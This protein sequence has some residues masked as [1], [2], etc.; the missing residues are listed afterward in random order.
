MSSISG[1]NSSY[2]VLQLNPIVNQQL[3][4]D[5]A[6][7][8]STVSQASGGFSK[9]RGADLFSKLQ[10]LQTSDPE[11]FKQVTADIAQKLKDAAD[12]VGGDAGKRLSALADK[13]QQ[14][15]DTGDLSK[16]QPPQQAGANSKVL[17]AYQQN[18]QDGQALGA[19]KHAHH[20]HGGGGGEAA[21]TQQPKNDVWSSILDEV[22]QAISG[23]ATATAGAAE[24]AA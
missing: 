3:T 21:G 19:T 14:V 8:S 6:V 13:F 23:S 16:L 17:G 1:I 15:S 22:N 9:S 5:N 2:A 4:A 12:Q 11:K 10:Q 7:D 18:S 24:Q 20:H